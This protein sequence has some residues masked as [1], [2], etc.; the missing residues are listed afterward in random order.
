[1]IVIPD[2]DMWAVGFLIQMN[3]AHEIFSVIGLKGAL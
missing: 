3:D 1:M 2:K